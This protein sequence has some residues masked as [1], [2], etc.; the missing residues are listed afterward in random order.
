MGRRGRV[1]QG[2]AFRLGLRSSWSLHRC[3]HLGTMR[4][5]IDNTDI[6]YAERSSM[7]RWCNNAAGPSTP[8][9]SSMRSDHR[10]SDDAIMQRWNSACMVEHRIPSNGDVRQARRDCRS[11]DMW[12]TTHLYVRVRTKTTLH[13]RAHQSPCITAASTDAVVTA[14]HT[15]KPPTTP[16][17]LIWSRAPTPL[18]RTDTARVMLHVVQQSACRVGTMHHSMHAYHARLKRSLN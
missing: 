6:D 14:K 17:I 8:Q 2:P 4:T 18:A 7:Y 10:C 15:L 16:N 1:C 5:T 9:A 3:C 11:C 12:G 13:T